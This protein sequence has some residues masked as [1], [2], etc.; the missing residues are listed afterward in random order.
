MALLRFQRRVAAQRRTATLDHPIA[1]ADLLWAIGSVCNLQRAPFEASLMQSQFPP[2]HTTLTLVEAARAAGFHAEALAVDVPALATLPQPCLVLLVPPRPAARIPADECRATTDAGNTSTP[3]KY[4]VALVVKIENDRVLYF[5]A[6]TNTPSIATIEEFAGLFAGVA[7]AVIPAERPVGDD[8]PIRVPVRFGFRWF[9]PELLKHKRIWRDVLF[10][11]LF[12]Q[13]I[14]LAVPLC[15]QIIIDKVIVHQTSST[16]LVIAVALTI[17][18][19]FSAGL[20]WI[21]QYL[22]SHTGNR[23]DAVL[24]M[25]VFAHLFRLPLRYFERR[26]T[27]VIAARL[28]GVETI[29]DFLSGAAVTLL[30]DC[31]F[32]VIF[33]ALMAIYSAWLTLITLA[34]LI[35]IVAI[36]LVVA[37]LF[38]QR[39]NQQFLLGAR[40]QAFLTE[41]IAG[42][43]TV[44]S[45]QM[46]PQL[47]RRYEGY[48]AAYLQSNFATRQLANTYN[49]VANGLEQLMSTAILCLGAWLVMR[50]ADFTIGMLVAFQMFANRVSQPMLRLVGLW[51][52][53]QQATIAVQRLADIM[54]APQEPYAIAPS[55]DGAGPG[56]IEFK[57]VAFRYRDELPFLFRNMSFAIAPG[58]CVV[59]MGP[60]GC[61]KSTLAKLLQGFC[62]PSDGQVLIDDRD[63]RHFAANE[64]RA[65]FGVVPQETMLFSGTVYDNLVIANPFATF[66]QIVE[67]C[68]YAEIHEAIAALPDGYQTEIGE[69]GVGLSGGQKQRIAIARALLKRPRILI[70]DEATSNLDAPTADHIARTINGLKGKV[71]LLFISHQVP[72]G[73]AADLAIRIAEPLARASG[74]N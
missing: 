63:S 10:A 6:G 54:N 58:Q 53:F 13:L 23:V 65:Y 38:Q 35:A 37:P 2:P 40:N 39:L 48:L 67:A 22:V 14:A 57:S 43:E 36:S 50:S 5:R 33:L 19:V 11:S 47:S 72:R 71:T 52:Q 4:G 25:A 34:I 73:L 70:F 15:S 12:I 68:R 30:L 69:R 3:P 32:L 45:L 28:H 61:G 26:A 17:F 27:G 51:Q 18:L 21:R 20:S 29:R 16:L 44:K 41:Y 46:E 74:G 7:L 42:M 24:G 64:L 55:R 8:D 49:T 59:V 56:R 62:V 60:S 31:P 9:V 66:E 1:P